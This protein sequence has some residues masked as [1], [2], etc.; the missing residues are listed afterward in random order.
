MKEHNIVAR[1]RAEN[2]KINE[3]EDEEEKKPSLVN[4]SNQKTGATNSVEQTEESKD[5]S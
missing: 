2:A 1:A 3:F 5:M 4:Q